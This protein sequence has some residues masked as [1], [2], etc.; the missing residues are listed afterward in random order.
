LGIGIMNDWMW[1]VE[2]K[3]FVQVWM[4]ARYLWVFNTPQ[5]FLTCSVH[6]G[7]GRYHNFIIG[8]RGRKRVLLY[9]QSE[10]PFLY[11]LPFPQSSQADAETLLLDPIF[12]MAS[13]EPAH[14]LGERPAHSWVANL[15]D[16]SIAHHEI[17]V[18]H[19]EYNAPAELG[20]VQNDHPRVP[21]LDAASFCFFCV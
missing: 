7:V 5:W 10:T 12:E 20:E 4:A 3:N 9:P 19:F 2:Y 17:G 8:V 11:L 18:F 6:V 1:H 21:R 15:D 16:G 14:D 13:Y